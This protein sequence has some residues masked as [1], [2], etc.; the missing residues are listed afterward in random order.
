MSQDLKDLPIEAKIGQLFFIG[1][2]GTELDDATARLLDEIQPGGVC[3]FSRNIREATQTR[4]LLDAIRDRS[5]AEPFL[6]LDQEGGTVDRLRR[7]VTPLAAADRIRNVEEAAEMG[8]LIGETISLLGFNMDFAPVVDVVDEERSK[9]SNGLFSR[10]FG[11]SKEEVVDFA[12]A[13]LKSLQRSGP[14][15]CLK[16]FPGLGAATVDSH[17]ELPAINVGQDEFR[18]T[19]LHPYR[20]LIAR[21]DVHAVMVAHAGF[22]G[23]DLQERDQSGKLLPSS[24]SKNIITNLLRGEL[25]Y[26]RLVITDDLEM[27]AIIK[28]FG[29]GEAAVRAIV[30][31]VDMVAICADPA[32]VRAG[33][34]AVVGA[35][36][37]G[38]ISETDLDERISRIADTKMGIPPCV[39]FDPEKL[40]ELSSNT[41]LF[42]DSLAAN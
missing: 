32:A 35:V 18:A 13:F 4:A 31:G 15:G 34:A 40:A 38:R 1:I 22:P 14:L 21:G 33:F 9:Y 11:R 7:I 28:N 8:T 27:G 26:D 41:A 3:L 6:S 29:V 37:S 17:E 5:A 23:I 10:P 36:E 39:P 2:A 42:N 16:H 30:A 12:G 24:L 25:G 20:E 19:D